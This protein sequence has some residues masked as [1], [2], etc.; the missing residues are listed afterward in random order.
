MTLDK[1]LKEVIFHAEAFDSNVLRA[2]NARST[3]RHGYVED[4]CMGGAIIA[5]QPV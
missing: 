5:E 4:M 1:Q 2:V 3:D